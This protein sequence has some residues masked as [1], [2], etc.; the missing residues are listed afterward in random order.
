MNVVDEES[1]LHGVAV[2]VD[3]GDETSTSSAK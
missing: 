2:M 3:K 1:R